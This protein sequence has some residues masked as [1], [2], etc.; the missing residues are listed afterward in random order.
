MREIVLD[1]FLEKANIN[2]SFGYFCP[3]I[4]S[5][6]CAEPGKVYESRFLLFGVD[7]LTTKKIMNRFTRYS[8]TLKWVDA[9]HCILDF[10]SI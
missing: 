5:G 7:L 10:P 9:S 2:I 1:Y 8:P 4:D 3:R 6:L